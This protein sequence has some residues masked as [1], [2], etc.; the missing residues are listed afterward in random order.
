MILLSLVLFAGGAFLLPAQVHV[1]RSIEIQR[2]VSTVYTIVNGFESFA[3]WSPRLVRDPAM[4][5]QVS[6]PDSGPGARLEWQGDPRQVGSGWQEITY[7]EPY[8][9]VKTDVQ[10]EQQSIYRTYFHME[11][12]AGGVRLTWGLDTDLTS[13]QGFAGSILA[14]WFGLFFDRWIGADFEQGLKRLKTFA[15]SLP[16]V[17]FA[18]LEIEIVDVAPVDVLYV[19]VGGEAQQAGVAGTMAEAF[20]EIS[21]FMAEQNLVM[22][23][24]PMAITRSWDEKGF[25][26]DAAIPVERTDV[27]PQGKVRW[28]QSPSGRAVRFVHRGSY[29]SMAPSYEK[30]AA[31]MAVHGLVEGKI[32]WEHYISDPIATDPDRLL[33]HIYFLVEESS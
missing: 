29:D 31:Y 26:I 4:Q 13:G 6:G 27:Q 8:R 11:N 22:S 5:Y 23:A 32:S 16:A 21:T 20:R 2:P 33:T 15:E 30:L 3:A 12:V 7:S 17:D 18:G 9:L 19:P 25:H 24:Q 1:E 28:G 14:R 10:A